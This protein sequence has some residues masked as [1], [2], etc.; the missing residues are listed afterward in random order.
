[1]HPSHLVPAVLLL[2]A[3]GLATPTF[4]QSDHAHVHGVAR[5]DVAVDGG[6]VELRL[7]AAMQD[8]VG[9]ERAPR[10]AE[11]E[12]RLQSAR[13]AL[14]DHARLWRFN[15]AAGCVAEGPVLEAP[16]A[17]HGVHGRHG[18]DGHDGHDDGAHADW[19]VRYR[20]QCSAPTA[21]QAID[22]GVFEVFPSLESVDVQVIDGAG[23][24]AERL[25]P[26]VRRITVTP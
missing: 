6:R 18:R 7:T 3:C 11:E 5:L 10:S 4:A 2:L 1:M 13:K 21:L 14:L 24:R 8:F 15:A 20:F 9:F 25:S 19:T 22:G 23:A 26:S 17:A 16:G 12:A